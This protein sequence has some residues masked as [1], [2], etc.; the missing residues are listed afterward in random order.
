MKLEEQ[1]EFVYKLI[2][3]MII[4]TQFNRTAYINLYTATI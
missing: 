1:N 2:I 4:I 3:I